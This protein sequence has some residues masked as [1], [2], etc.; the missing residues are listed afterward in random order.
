[1]D[2]ELRMKLSDL[3][4]PEALAD[5]I[6]SHFA[7]IAV[8]IPLQRIAEAVGIVEVIGHKTGSFEG[9]L[10]TNSAK[11]VGSIAYNEA[12]KPE[13]R[14][15]TIAHELGHFLMP[16]HGANAQCAKIDMDVSTP[17]DSQRAREVEA[18][19]FSAA[20]LMPRSLF[21]MDMRRLGAPEVEHII[22]LANKY[23]VSKEAAVRRYT[24]LCDDPCAVIFSHSGVAGHIYKT[25]NFP[26][27]SVRKGQPLPRQC[28]SAQRELDPGKISE[29]SETIPEVWLP[30]TRRL[31]NATLYEQFL[32]QSNGFRMTMLTIDGVP[33]DDDD[34]DEEEQLEE[35]WT[36]RFRR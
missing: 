21:L 9:V 30:D 20:L 24:D 22:T 16:L 36:P 4:S 7:D 35:S 25:D 14:W 34:S 3:G 15:F 33:V 26:L 29:C 10:V 23:A 8:P 6:V 13:R 1:M 17:A 5:C 19:R 2:D 12:S 31:R 32:G 18:N 27:I 11:R 28:I